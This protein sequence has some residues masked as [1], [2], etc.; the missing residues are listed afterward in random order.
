M[1]GPVFVDT[2]VLVYRADASDRLKQ[3]RAD[4][5]YRFLW[6]SRAGRL[7]FQILL[8]LYSILTRKLTPGFEESEAREIVRELTAWQPIPVDLTVVERAWLLQRD[9]LL[10]WWDALVVAA[11]QTCECRVLLTEDLQDGQVFDAV[12]VVSPF[13]LPNRTPSEVL[14]GLAP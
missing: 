9:H 12:R 4:A 6:R 5:W 2:N 14:E 11:A 8:E 3:A 10:S 1:T 13:A 7:S